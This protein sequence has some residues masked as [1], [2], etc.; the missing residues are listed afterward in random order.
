MVCMALS[1]FGSSKAF[2]KMSGGLNTHTQT[3]AAHQMRSKLGLMVTSAQRIVYSAG[4][5]CLP[6]LAL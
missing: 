5:K 6:L 2:F 3:V 1:M 4:R